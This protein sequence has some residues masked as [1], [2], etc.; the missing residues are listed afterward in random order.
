MKFEL[1]VKPAENKT[2]IS[3]RNKNR[4]FA[5]FID[6]TKDAF[7]FYLENTKFNK[8]IV[9]P[10]TYIAKVEL[11]TTPDKTLHGIV[12]YTGTGKEKFY[13]DSEQ[14][15]KLAALFLKGSSWII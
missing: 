4:T 2:T 6:I 11:F 8:W 14:F 5:K 9:I 1:K 13:V 3:K 10:K 7:I 15:T 12:L